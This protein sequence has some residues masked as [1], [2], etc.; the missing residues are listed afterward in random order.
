MKIYCPLC[1]TKI[2]YHEPKEDCPIDKY[3][4]CPKCDTYIAVHASTQDYIVRQAH[5]R[6]INPPG[7]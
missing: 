2:N 4:Q 5:I 3:P 7:S 6:L 1:G